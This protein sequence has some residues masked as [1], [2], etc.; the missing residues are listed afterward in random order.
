MELIVITLFLLTGV[1]ANL[2]IIFMLKHTEDRRSFLFSESILIN[3]SSFR[4]S[5]SDHS[6]DFPLMHRN[7]FD[8]I[9]H[10]TDRSDFQT[11]F[12]YRKKV[13]VL[14]EFDQIARSEAKLCVAKLGGI[15]QNCL[16][17]DTDIL[18]LGENYDM[19]KIDCI[20]ELDKD[21]ITQI[22]ILD[23]FMFMDIIYKYFDFTFGL[24]DSE[25]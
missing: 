24:F 19:A 15:L 20:E 10:G 23:E 9:F 7:A 18:V 11:N 8:S 21:K 1:V 14:G 3:S 13:L 6:G 25:P 16:D 5:N 4:F 12:F 17:I 22:Q 2:L